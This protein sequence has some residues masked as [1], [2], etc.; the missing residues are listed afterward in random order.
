LLHDVD[1]KRAHYRDALECLEQVDQVETLLVMK[2]RKEMPTALVL[3]RLLEKQ[4]D[5]T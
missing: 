1:E 3:A 2:P 5:F 4:F